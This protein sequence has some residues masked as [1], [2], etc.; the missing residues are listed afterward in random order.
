MLL[1]RCGS[2]RQ[3]QWSLD[4]LH[5]HGLCRLIAAAARGGSS[6]ARLRARGPCART[7]ITQAATAH[8]QGQRICEG[9]RPARSPGARGGSTTEL[10]RVED[11]TEALCHRLS[12]P[13]HAEICGADLRGS[14]CL[15]RGPPLPAPV[16]RLVCQGSLNRAGLHAR[17]SP[18]A[19]DHFGAKGLLVAGFA[20]APRLL[21]CRHLA[22][23]PAAPLARLSL[24]AR[25]PDAGARSSAS[26][27]STHEAIA[28][29]GIHC[30]GGLLRQPC[31]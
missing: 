27:G 14:T 31:P 2:R 5:L 13:K 20:A 17:S 12:P 7:S 1:N 25:P 22:R 10:A 3:G 23:G 28:Q 16:P 8:S 29:A 9:L 24:L 4:I 21:A 30:R 26:A 11:S 18:G 6:A 15:R 19:S